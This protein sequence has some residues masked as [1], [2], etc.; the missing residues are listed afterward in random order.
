MYST[1]GWLLPTW[2]CIVAALGLAALL[3]RL[4]VGTTLSLAAMIA[5]FVVVIGNLLFPDTLALVLPTPATGEAIQQA[6]RGAM[7]AVVEQAAP[8]AVSKEFL[9]ITCAGAWA[10]TVS[11]DGLAFRAGQP[12]LAM[13][14]ALGL[15]VFPAMI[16]PSGP[17]W[18]TLWFLL[19]AGVLLLQEGRGRL[20]G[21]GQWVASPRT[22][23]GGRWR[24]PVSPANTTARRLAASAGVLALAVPWALPG[25]G[26]EPL[27]NYRGD[28]GLR[29]PRSRSTRSCRSS[30][31]WPPGATSRCSPSGPSGAA[32]GG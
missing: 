16:R 3:R 2:I 24:L 18:Y 6:A 27:L 29:P 8:A 10:V 25:Y 21:W 11:A 1:G 19:G 13:V 31:T 17:G 7:E 30:R 4:G 26:R 23:P 15:F 12:L 14:P 5:G 28:A 22:R 20:A 9:L 32:T